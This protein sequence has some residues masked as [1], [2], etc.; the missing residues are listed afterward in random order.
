LTSVVF[1]A[2]ASPEIGAGHVMRCLALAKV[3]TG[4]GCNSVF[5]V[6]PETP[7]TVPA[8]E[9]AGHEIQIVDAAAEDLVKTL[10]RRF[11]DPVDW[12][13]IDHYEIDAGTE[14]MFRSLARNIMVIDDLADRPHDCDLLLDQAPGRDSDDYAG[15]VPAH[16]DVLAGPGYALLDP[17]YGEYRDRDLPGKSHR[18]ASIFVSF[19]ATDP[20]NFTVRGLDALEGAALAGP[21]NVVLGAAAP[22]REAVRTRLKAWD[23]EA[24][25]HIDTAEIIQLLA[26][27]MLAVGAGGVS[28]LERCC[29]GVPSVIAV[30]ADNQHAAA[31]GICAAGAAE[32]IDLDD[33]TGASISI[34]DFAGQPDNL[35][36][37]TVAGKL[38]CD[39]RGGRRVAMALVPERSVNGAPVRLRP[40]A[41]EDEN[42]ILEWQRSP[43]ARRFARNPDVPAAATH[44]AWMKTTLN[45]PEVLLNIIECERRAAGLLRLD[46]RPD[47]E[48]FPAFE[49]SILVA[50]D[51]HRAGIGKAGL[52]LARRLVPG[53]V[54]LAAIHRDN[55][56]SLS[57]FHGAGY[58]ADGVGYASWPAGTPQNGL[59]AQ[60]EMHG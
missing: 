3:L 9:R 42:R 29:C 7:A 6:S 24:N 43:G 54:L 47:R 32:L 50:P 19:G 49:V 56:P 21:V 34:A 27:S 33:I 20:R 36:R 40:A 48:S 60:G 31:A 25:L 53:A 52:V 22:H 59:T 51:Q 11:T 30:T 41:A 2:D 15:L 1:R 16:A 4:L 14:S 44:A 55:T 39:G 26:D 5:A 35:V 37:K 38:L 12:M 45:D 23:T 58:I 46:R 57:L 10:T 17:A 13:V 18:R 8:L 28:A